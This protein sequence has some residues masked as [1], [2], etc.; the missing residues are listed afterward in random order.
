MAETLV[1]TKTGT[2][3][4]PKPEWVDYKE[5]ERFEKCLNRSYIRRDKRNS[6]EFFYKVIGM[7]PTQPAVIFKPGEDSVMPG[8]DSFMINFEVQKFYRNKLVDSVVRDPSSPNN[9]TSVKVNQ[10]V[11][12]HEEKNGVFVLVDAD[13]SFF[14][15]ARQFLKE[16]ELDAIE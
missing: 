2:A 6:T 11:A 15:D 4:S 16:F 7:H 9:K 13:A 5:V 3:N 10:Q 8:N 1:Q 14:K 12:Q